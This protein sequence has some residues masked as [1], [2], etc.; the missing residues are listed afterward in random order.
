MNCCEGLPWPGDC[1]DEGILFTSVTRLNRLRAAARV[2]YR[3]IALQTAGQ[4]ETGSAI[5]F[6]NLNSIMS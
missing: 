2:Q 4:V 1:S 5:F 3:G 6:R